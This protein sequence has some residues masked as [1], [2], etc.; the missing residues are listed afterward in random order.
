M[1]R[2]THHDQAAK[3]LA[4]RGSVVRTFLGALVVVAVVAGGVWGAVQFSKKSLQ[5][6]VMTQRPIRGEFIHDVVEPGDIESAENVDIVCDVASPDGVRII[7]IAEEGTNVQPG[8]LLV[9]LDDSTIRKDL[10]AQKIAVNTSLAALAKAQNDL[11]AARIALKEYEFGTFKQEEE[12]LLSELF[13]A[14]E[15]H[16][17]AVNYFKHSEKL[18]LRGYITEIQLQ[19][20]RFSME[21]YQKELDVAK[22]KLGVLREFTKAKQMMDFDSKV[23]TAET[24]FESE[25]AKYKLEEEKLA[26]LEEQLKGCVIL[27]PSSGQVVYNNMNRWGDESRMIRK[28]NKVW[29]RQ[30]IMRLPNRSRMQVRT[31]VSEAKVDRVK[32]GM[33]VRVKFEALP[34]T[35]LT[36]SVKSISSY[37][38]EENW[39]NPNIKRYETLIELKETPPQ[40]RP[41]M[42]AEA[43]IRIEQIA[44]A[45]MVPVQCVVE[46]RKRF[47]CLVQGPDQSIRAAAVEM[48]SS[49]DKHVV[50]VSGLSETD[51][52]VMN[53][54]PLLATV[55]L[56]ESNDSSSRTDD[57]NPLTEFPPRAGGISTTEDPSATPAATPDKTSASAPEAVAS[58][59]AT[60]SPATGAAS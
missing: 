55:G 18:A 14:E 25:Q 43:A 46:Y 51:D 1:R 4:R 11:D 27:S 42:T 19:A 54:R 49:N 17:R 24:A 3:P 56:V 59:P 2:A 45:L 8:D 7:E 30:T 29:Q 52:V 60:A 40:L 35:E 57:P 41:G 6:K 10:A 9:Q 37:A 44:N 33:A 26:S 21:K 58:P 31:K 53:P 13:V 23:K 34:N 28:G 16:R 36:G 5:Q 15:N 22:T 48:G 39:F 38:S 32:P 47:Y 12:K 20:D 50:I